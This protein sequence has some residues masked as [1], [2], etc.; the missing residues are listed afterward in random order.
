[1]RFQEAAK[2]VVWVMLC[3]TVSGARRL[4]GV[5]AWQESNAA[6]YCESHCLCCYPPGWLDSAV[7]PNSV[8]RR[9]GWGWCYAARLLSL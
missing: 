3:A 5:V 1:M 9:V 6:Y 2:R 7:E 4:A 8:T